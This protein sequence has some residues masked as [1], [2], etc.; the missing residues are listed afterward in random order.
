MNCY[1]S[2]TY[3]R[4]AIDSVLGQSYENWELI[5]WDNNSTD[6]SPDILRGY[7]DERIKYF[8]GAETRPLYNARNLALEQCSG[9]YVG[10]LDC[11]DVWVETK[12]AQ[13]MELAVNGADI[14][15]GG[16]STIDASGAVKMEESQ[17]LVSGN[18]TNSL[19][20]KNSISI[21]CILI[22]RSLLSGIYFDP[23]YDL[24]GD[25]D[26]WVKLSLSHQIVAVNSVVEYSRQ[27]GNN[28]SVKLL[29]KWLTERRYFY[30]KH[31][32][33]VNVLKYPWIMYYVLKTEALGLIGRR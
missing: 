20:K 9:D 24:L 1:N 17:Y 32:T 13:Q 7:N 10:F 6:K 28:T 30:R 12:L 3:L 25:Y 33:F 22:K 29:D 5:F 31:L 23:Y 15:Y 18:I 8:K 27:H 16:Y 19:F 2:E 11:D 21:G 26:L 4:E 14:V